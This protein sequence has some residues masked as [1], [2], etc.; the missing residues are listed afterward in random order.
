MKRIL[1][2][3]VV[4]MLLLPVAVQGEEQGLLPSLADA[5]GV[6]MPSLGDVLH[7]YPDS[8]TKEADGGTVQHWTGITDEDFEAFAAWYLTFAEK[9]ELLGHTN[10]LL[11]I[12][13]KR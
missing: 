6:P 5:F 11:Y 3:F 9:R 7:R 12:C 2:L 4:L 13:R 8:E 1:V 10:H